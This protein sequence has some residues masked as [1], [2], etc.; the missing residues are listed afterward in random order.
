MEKEDYERKL[1]QVKE[2][3][4]IDLFIILWIFGEVM[5]AFLFKDIGGWGYFFCS[6]IVVFIAWKLAGKKS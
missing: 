3:H 6:W 1:D 4:R 5:L 2:S